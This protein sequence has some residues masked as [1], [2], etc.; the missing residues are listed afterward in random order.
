MILLHVCPKQSSITPKGLNRLRYFNGCTKESQRR[1]PPF[2]GLFREIQIPTVIRGYQIPAGTNVALNQMTLN[3][4]HVKSPTEFVPER[5]IRG[6]DHP[7]ADS[8]PKFGH[9]VFGYGRRQCPGRRISTIYSDVL[10]VKMLK[11]FRIEYPEQPESNIKKNPGLIQT[12]DSCK[13][14]LIKRNT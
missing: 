14:R 8:L 1:N 3:Q 10:K 9:L 5:F 4:M 12:P 11:E 2:L 13:L 7:L 6:S